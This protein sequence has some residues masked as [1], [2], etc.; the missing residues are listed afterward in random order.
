MTATA[1]AAT[2]RAIENHCNRVDS[3]K[4]RTDATSAIPAPSISTKAIA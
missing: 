1:I 4:P 3:R 2:E